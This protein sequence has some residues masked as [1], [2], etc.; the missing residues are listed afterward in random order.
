MAKKKKKTT[1]S[2][3][4]SLEVALEELRTIVSELESG[5]T[6]LEE[7]LEKYE[8]GIHLVRSCHGQLDAAHQ[9]IEIVTA[10][11]P[12]GSLE[13]DPFAPAESD[14]EVRARSSARTEPPSAES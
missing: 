1:D 13:T 4:P 9:R 14:A 12:D 2:E 11:K 7:L 5:E 3:E 6:P 8:R 10:A